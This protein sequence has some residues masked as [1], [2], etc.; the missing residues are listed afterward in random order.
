MTIQKK[1]NAFTHHASSFDPKDAPNHCGTAPGAH[2]DDTYGG[3][4]ITG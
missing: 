2:V 1:H 4:L 3:C